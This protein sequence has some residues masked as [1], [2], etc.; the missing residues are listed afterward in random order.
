MARI[1]VHPGGF[2]KRNYIDELG[3]TATELADALEV[4]ESTLSRLVHEKIDLSPALAVKVLGR[5]AESWM[6]MQANHTLARYQA[7]LEQWAPPKQVT[8]EG[9]VAVKGGKSKA[10]RKAAAKTATA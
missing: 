2:I 6:A 5:S 10:R 1:T 7:E 3:L 4:S 8:A 9:L